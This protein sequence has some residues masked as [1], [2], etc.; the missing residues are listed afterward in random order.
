MKASITWLAS[1]PKSGNTWVRLFLA[2][3]IMD[4]PDPLP[5]NQL[6]KFG[7]GDTIAAMYHAAAGRTVNV[8]D[9][10]LTMRL[11]DLV[12]RGIINNKADINLVKTHNRRT[13]AYGCDLIPDKYTRSAIYIVRNPLDMV[14]SYARHYGIRNEV[15]AEQICHPDNANAPTSS[16][17]VEFLGSWS[18]HVVSWTSKSSYPVL[19]LRYEDLLSQP[20]TEF[21][22]VVEHFG[23]T[24]EPDRLRRAIQHASFDQLQK[25]EQ[26]H[27]FIEASDKSTAFFGK[28]QAGQWRSELDRVLV[29]RIRQANKRVM[30]QYGYWNE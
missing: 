6:H 11:R 21:T 28:G 12:L 13:V 3:Y 17:V 8:S 18:D 22:K 2:N 9:L 16:T 4:K 1:Y 7:T 15:A 19:V 29:K 20:E 10:A 26:Q 30:K 5:I 23:M 25:Q 27:G 24:V 14:L